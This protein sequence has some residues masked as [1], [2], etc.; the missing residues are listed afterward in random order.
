M[1][2]ILDLA[3]TDLS[4]GG[5]VHMNYISL[6]LDIFRNI[7]EILLVLDKFKIRKSIFTF[8]YKNILAI[9][10]INILLIFLI[11]LTENETIDDPILIALTFDKLC[12]TLPYFETLP[13]FIITFAICG[14]N[15]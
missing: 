11:E 3:T 10:L 9:V 15:S 12:K 5:H 14:I 2:N 7:N 13:E 8:S 1:N 4:Y 6:I